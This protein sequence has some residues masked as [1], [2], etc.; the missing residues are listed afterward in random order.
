MHVREYEAQ[1]CPIGCADCY[2]TRFGTRAYS[3]VIRSAFRRHSISVPK[4]SDQDS[5]AFDPISASAVAL[6]SRRS[7]STPGSWLPPDGVLR[8]RREAP[9]LLFRSFRSVTRPGVWKWIHDP[10]NRVAP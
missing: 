8:R 3:D 2:K 7:W 5:G 4:V 10:E 1:F 9:C 6:P